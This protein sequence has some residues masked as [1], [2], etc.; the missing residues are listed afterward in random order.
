MIPVL[1]LG[2]EDLLLV[3]PWEFWELL[4]RQSL[5]GYGHFRLHLV[6]DFLELSLNLLGLTQIMLLKV[7]FWLK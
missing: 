5:V 3:A 4:D 6:N 2:L 1:L 7:K